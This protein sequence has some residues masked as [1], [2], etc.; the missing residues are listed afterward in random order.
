MTIDRYLLD[1]LTECLS[2]AT[3]L[4][5]DTAKYTLGPRGDSVVVTITTP[6]PVPQANA[7]IARLDDWARLQAVRCDGRLVVDMEYV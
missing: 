6:L 1:L 7:A 4:F 3:R 5:G 2:Q